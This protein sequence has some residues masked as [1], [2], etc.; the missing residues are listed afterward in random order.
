MYNSGINIEVGRIWHKIWSQIVPISIFYWCLRED[1][2]FFSNVRVISKKTR[3]FCHFVRIGM[4]IFSHGFA[5]GHFFAWIREWTHRKCSYNK[6]TSSLEMIYCKRTY[7][8]KMSHKRCLRITP[9]YM[10][11]CLCFKTDSASETEPETE[12]ESESE[13]E[14][15][16]EEEE[17]EPEPEPAKAERRPYRSTMYH[18]N[19]LL[20]VPPCRTRPCRC[21]AFEEE[22]SD[23]DSEP[24]PEP[25]RT[26]ELVPKA[27]VPE[28]VKTE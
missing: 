11:P 16:E 18:R 2:F 23:S 26:E 24:E 6:L 3:H 22:D 9:C 14:E 28:P 1:S 17:E 27:E 8:R 5:N 7:R 19:S 21:F 13:E 10:L 12:P 25:A 15:S 20:R 4:D